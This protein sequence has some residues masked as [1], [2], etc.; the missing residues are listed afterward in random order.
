MARMGYGRYINEGG[1][2]LNT[3]TH[4]TLLIDSIP[5]KYNQEGEEVKVKVTKLKS[6]INHKRRSWL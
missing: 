4:L 1:P 5:L 3:Y 6:T 2:T